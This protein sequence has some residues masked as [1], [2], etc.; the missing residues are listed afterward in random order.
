MISGARYIPYSKVSVELCPES[1][2]GNA[3]INMHD[4]KPLFKSSVVMQ[5]RQMIVFYAF[6]HN[7]D[8]RQLSY[9]VH[10]FLR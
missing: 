9:K 2:I 4:T 7:G 6:N 8:A 5:K 1:Q 3:T 10:K